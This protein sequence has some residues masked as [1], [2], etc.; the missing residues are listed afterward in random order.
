MPFEGVDPWRWQYFEGVICPPSV[1]VPVDDPTGWRLYPTFRRVYD[2]LFICDSQG[3]VSGPHGVMPKRF[4]VF[5]KPGT[6][7]HG[8]G[9]GGRII[10]SAAEMEASFTPGHIWMRLLNGRHVS[11]DVALVRGRLKWCRHTVGISLPGGM[12]DYWKILGTPLPALEGV[13]EAWIGRHLRGF[14]GI[15][16]FE[17]IGG[18]IIEC[19]LR[20]SE[21]WID[22]NGPGWLPS[23]VDLYSCGRWRYLHRPRTG[24][25]VALFGRHQA[26]Y[27]IDPLSVAALRRLPGVSSIQITFDPAKPREQH[28]MPPGGF[29]LAIVNCWDLAVGLAA[30]QR[31]KRIFTVV[32]MNGATPPRQ[33]HLPQS[34]KQVSPGHRPVGSTVQAFKAVAR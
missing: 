27:T 5:S 11:T 34:A 3:I 18:K 7:L 20:M 16:N 24:Y 26:Y 15:V 17:T 23:V 31:L 25:S 19:H 4:P 13:L 30:R 33:D 2:K 9:I 21:Q 28:A 32:S 8:M 22:I 29:R 12:F 1:I 6:N 10:R 14:T